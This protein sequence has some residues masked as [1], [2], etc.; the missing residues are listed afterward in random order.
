MIPVI[1]GGVIAI[2]RAAAVLSDDDSDKNFEPTEKREV[3]EEYVMKYI[4]N[5]DKS[6]PIS[7][8][9]RNIYLS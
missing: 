5:A 7:N 2:A 8:D 9:T 4:K 6:T 3:T 1:V